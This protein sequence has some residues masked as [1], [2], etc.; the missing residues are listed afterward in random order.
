MP[1]NRNGKMNV[2]C[3]SDFGKW[4]V[5]LYPKMKG[6]TDQSRTPEQ[7]CF[8]IDPSSTAKAVA[9]LPAHRALPG[10]ASSTRHS[11]ARGKAGESDPGQEETNPRIFTVLQAQGILTSRGGKTSCCGGCRRMVSHASRGG[12]YPRDIQ[13]RQAQWYWLSV[14][15]T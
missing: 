7:F 15:A 2:D 10:N 4:S 1:A 6:P 14:R 11:E 5:S 9:R 12:G 3:W 13:C 8:P